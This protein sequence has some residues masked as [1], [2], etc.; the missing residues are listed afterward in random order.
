MANPRTSISSTP[1]DKLASNYDEAFS[2]SPLGKALR[3]AVWRRIEPHLRPDGSV[4][5][6]GCGT[7]V[8]ALRLAEAGMK[9]VAVDAS[10]RMVETA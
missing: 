7:G 8:D 3:A 2:E 6:L 10:E 9:V 4:L 5:E 1:F